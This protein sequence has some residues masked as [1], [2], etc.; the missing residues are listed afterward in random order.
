MTNLD[1]IARSPCFGDCRLEDKGF[2][3]AVSSL[4]RKTIVGIKP[5]MKSV[6]LFCKM[7]KQEQKHDPQGRFNEYTLVIRRIDW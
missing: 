1:E 4:P 7:Q 6:L 2:A 3:S 5:A